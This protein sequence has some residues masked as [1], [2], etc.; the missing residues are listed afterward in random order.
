MAQHFY[1]AP[2]GSTRPTVRMFRIDGTSGI[3]ISVWLLRSTHHIEH[4]VD[5]GL[6]LLVGIGL[7]DIAGSLD[8]LIDIGIIKRE[9]HKLAH[10]PLLGIETG[11]SRML[12]GIGS[13]LEILVAVLTLALAES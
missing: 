6:H 12:Q 11:M 10:V 9:A 13:H 7:Q 2:A 1:L 3:E 5:I 8:G 4:T